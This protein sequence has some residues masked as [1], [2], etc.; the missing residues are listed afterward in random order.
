MDIFAL[1][2]DGKSSKSREVRI[3]LNGQILQVSGN[4]F[5]REAPLKEL[6]ISEYL[7]AAPR[8]IT[9]PDGAFCEVRDQHNF[10]TLLAESGYQE[11][12][13]MRLQFSKRGIL[14]SLALCLLLLGAAYFWGVPL[15]AQVASKAIP[16]SIL[17]NLSNEA[18]DFLDEDWL[19]ETELEKARQE[20][21]KAQLAAIAI[22][23]NG[24]KIAHE[25]LF[26][27]NLAIPANAFALPSGQIILTD[28]LVDL[29][30]ND[31]EILAVLAHEL[32]HVENRHAMRQII[33]GSIVGAISAWLI[34]DF[35][36]FL[37]FVPAAFLEARYSRDFES[38]S[39]AYA[40]QMLAKNGISPVCLVDILNRLSKEEAEEEEKEEDK[41]TESH[42]AKIMGYLKSHPQTKDRAQALKGAPCV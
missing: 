16:Q 17:V 41:Y 32:G 27:N 19:G 6:R 10:K 42:A 20:S 1:Y 4:D 14:A 15:L 3:L 21:L 30:K 37:S 34:G 35:T 26:R 2:Y 13:A 31:H 9:F 39:D 29:A 12:V 40:A 33:Q 22:D 18:L 5:A 8:L 25:L 24:N 11:S 28:D 23:E 38:E 36:S 7:G